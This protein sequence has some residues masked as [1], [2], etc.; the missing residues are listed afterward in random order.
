MNPFISDQTLLSLINRPA[1]YVQDQH[2]V[3]VNDAAKARMISQGDPLSK[4][5][6]ELPQLYEEFR[7]GCLF[8]NLT[9]LN[10]QYPTCVTRQ[11]AGDLFV[12]D[13]HTDS[14]SQSL[15]LAAVQLRQSLNT[16]YAAMEDIPAHMR[17]GHMNQALMQMHR[18]LCNMSDLSR[19]ST[20]RSARMAATNITSVF[21]ETMEKCE[22]LLAK[23]GYQLR[24]SADETVFTMADREMVE[25]ALWN[26]LSNAAK[27]SKEGSRLEASMHR[28][29]NVIRFTVQDP[30]DGIQP[31]IMQQ[32]YS[33]YLREPGFEDSRHGLGLGLAIVSAVAGLH[34]GTVL[35]DQPGGA[36]TR[37]TMTI[38]VTP[39][40][41][42]VLRSPS[43]F[44]LGDYCG[45]FDRGL[46]ELSEILPANAYE[47][48][49]STN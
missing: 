33:R 40:P 25:R 15:A 19:Y 16:V 24:F 29:G 35:I 27:F 38:T 31:E 28:S 10:T 21:T 4:Y 23:A 49:K 17:P 11:E 2:I 12:L 48:Q 41:D 36:G 22:A 6:P 18:V 5:L 34:G 45:G 42:H 44:I 14:T 3:Y 7:N 32:I 37:V 39:C 30:G 47:T 20:P 46:L 26:M 9:I 43:S 8:L 1:F 13:V